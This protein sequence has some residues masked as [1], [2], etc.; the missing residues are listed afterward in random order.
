MGF[1]AKD[2]VAK[3]DFDFGYEDPTGWV[4][5][6][7]GVT[8]EPSVAQVRHFRYRLRELSGAT[9]E[10]REELEK[11]LAEMSEE[12][13][14][15]R[16]EE[17]LDEIAAVTS[18]QPSREDIAALPHRLQQA[19]IGSLVGDLFTP[20]AHAGGTRPSLGLVKTG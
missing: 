7:K 13:F 3:L 15:A 5:G 20:E 11:A 8:P 14:A 4:D 10:D 1:K 17:F 2:A 9:S 12:E 6:P 18:G 19:Y 16:D